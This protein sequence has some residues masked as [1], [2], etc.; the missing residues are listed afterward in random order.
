CVSTYSDLLVLG[1][2]R[3]QIVAS[4]TVQFSGGSSQF[5]VVI[6]G[7]LADHSHPTN[8]APLTGQDYEHLLRAVFV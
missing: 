4:V 7:A 6:H 8:P 2:S 5:E 3:P 1:I